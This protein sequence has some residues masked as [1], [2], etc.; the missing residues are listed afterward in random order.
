MEDNE[1]EINRALKEGYK[2]EIKDENFKKICNWN[3]TKKIKK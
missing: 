2:E 3:K 1:E